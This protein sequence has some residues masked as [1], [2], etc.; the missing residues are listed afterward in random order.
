MFTPK[1]FVSLFIKKNIKFHLIVLTNEIV[2]IQIGNFS[3]KNSSNEKM[4]GII[5]DSKLN[6]DSHINHSFSKA[7]KKSYITEKQNCQ[8][9]I[10]NAQ[11]NYC[12]LIWVLHSRR[13]NNKIKHLHER[14]LQ[15]IYSDN[16]L[17]LSKG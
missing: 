4:L 2:Q 8:E 11:F 13:N 9:I 14:C 3:I 16:K 12:S 1:S 7:S 5:I 17:S 15:L 6:C 10:F